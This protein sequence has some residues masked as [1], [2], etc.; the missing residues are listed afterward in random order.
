[1]V[2]SSIERML[3]YI[4]NIGELAINLSQIPPHPEAK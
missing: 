4:K 1:M 2:I 3:D